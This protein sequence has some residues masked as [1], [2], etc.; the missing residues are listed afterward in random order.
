MDPTGKS[1]SAPFVGGGSGDGKDESDAGAASWRG[2]DVEL[3]VDGAGAGGQIVE[4][5]A[6]RDGGGVKALAIVADGEAKAGIGQRDELDLDA[7][8]GAVPEGVAHRFSDDLQKFG[9]GGT[10]KKGQLGGECDF[11]GLQAFSVQVIEQGADGVGKTLLI[12]G[13]GR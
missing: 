10:A 12:E 1:L 5:M 6:A 3:G 2:V 9:A 8:G 4:T 11:S 13:V 7:G